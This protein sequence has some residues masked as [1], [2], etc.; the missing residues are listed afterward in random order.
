MCEFL[1]FFFL[2]ANK[3]KHIK[4]FTSSLEKQTRWRHALHR[5]RAT[6]IR[7]IRIS[8]QCTPLDPTGISRALRIPST[9]FSVE[10]ST[11][12]SSPLVSLYRDRMLPPRRTTRVKD[13]VRKK[14]KKKQTHLCIYASNSIFIV[15]YV[16]I[17]STV[18]IYEP[19]HE[20][21]NVNPVFKYH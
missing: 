19:D 12:G 1:F 14:K 7:A 20:N 13:V 3:A 5:L 11:L 21:L 8:N 15:S 2:F 6:A 16:R 4:H 17:L 9:R 10:E 18:A